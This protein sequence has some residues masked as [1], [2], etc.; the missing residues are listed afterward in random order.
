[1]K[2]KKGF[3]LVEVLAIIVILGL[4]AVI[5]IPI[6][7]E[8]LKKTKR[9]AAKDSTYG[10]TE[11][12]K[13]YFYKLEESIDEPVNYTCDFKNKCSE[14]NIQGTRPTSGTI[15]IDS[16]GNVSGEVTFSDKYTFCIYKDNVYDGPCE[17]QASLNLAEEVKKTGIHIYNPDGTI[18]TNQIGTCIRFDIVV[19]TG[20]TAIPFCVIDET[21]DS[22]TLISRDPVGKGSIWGGNT[23]NSYGPNTSMSYVLEQTKGWDKV[24]VISNYTYDDS[25]NGTKTYG[26]KTISIENG[27]ATITRKDNTTETIGDESNKLRARLITYEEVM[28]ITKGYPSPWMADIWTLS[29][30]GNSS[31]NAYRITPATVSNPTM[32]TGYEIHD[33]A[34]IKP[35]IVMPKSSL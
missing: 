24:A 32:I 17:K 7:D 16:I 10:L 25:N 5:T 14:L 6:I 9:N 28:K 34:E 3:T 22:V 11:V 18:D 21:N 29:S 20:T 27:I 26:Y 4:I 23:Q 15:R 35:V 12:A 8:T 30:E 19:K 13:Q 2:N 33:S 1:M 31:G